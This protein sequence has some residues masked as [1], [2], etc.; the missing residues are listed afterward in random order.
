MIDVAIIIGSTRPDRQ[1]ID[2]KPVYVPLP[3]P[4]YGGDDLTVLKWLNT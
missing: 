1:E 3:V 4:S 2:G